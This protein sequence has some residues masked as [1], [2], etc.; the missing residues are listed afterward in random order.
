MRDRFVIGASNSTGDS[1]YPG[2]SPNSIPG[3]SATATLVSHSHT[4]NQHTHTFT[5]NSQGAHTHSH[6]RLTQ[7]TSYT[8]GSPVG[9]GGAAGSGFSTFTTGSSGAH[10]HSGSTGNPS[11][12]GTNSQGSSA[13]NANLPP[14]YALCYIMKT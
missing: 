13:T 5:T 1:T 3:G 4:I 2:L 11:N 10:T 12:T 8:S 6:S 7:N 14:Y 9:S